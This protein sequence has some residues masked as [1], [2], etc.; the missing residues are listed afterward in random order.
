MGPNDCVAQIFICGFHL[1]SRASAPWVFP[2]HMVTK[3][4]NHPLLKARWAWSVFHWYDHLAAIFVP[5]IGLK[6]IIAYIE[7]LTTFTQQA[8]N[9]S[10]QSLSL[11]NTEMSL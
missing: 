11:L 8:L 4:A 10:W 2:G 3:I 1:G 6:D 9:D 5:S 7:N